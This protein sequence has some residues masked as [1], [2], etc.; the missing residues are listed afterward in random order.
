MPQREMIPHLPPCEAQYKAVP[1]SPSQ[2]SYSLGGQIEVLSS[3]V[4]SEVQT[5]AGWPYEGV[6]AEAEEDAAVATAAP[7]DRVNSR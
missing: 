1:A 2:H 5:P 3:S 7:N 4:F 6:E